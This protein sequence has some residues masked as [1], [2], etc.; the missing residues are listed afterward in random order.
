MLSGCAPASQHGASRY[1]EGKALELAIASERGDAKEIAR[2]MKDEGVNPDKIFSS[3]EGVPLIAWPL[4]AENLDG[5]RAMLENGA[6][7]NARIVKHLHGK[8]FHF[9]NA[10]VYATG[11]EDPRYLKLL[12]EHG[13]DGNTRNSNNEMLLFQAFISGNKWQNVQTLIEQGARINEQNFDRGDSILSYYTTRGGFKQAYW[14]IEH[15]ADPTLSTTNLVDPTKPPRTKMVD[16]IY[17]EI[18]TP[19]NLPWQ[20]KCQQWLIARGIPRP[21]MPEHIRKKR[22]AFKFPSREEDIP[23]L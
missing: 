9:D 13:G 20:K 11:M 17:W 5:L 10:M 4:R 21:P 14:L 8:D 19:D 16:D 3:K 15:G 6:D 12:M 22:E 7:P 2:L 1:F 23:L 18:T